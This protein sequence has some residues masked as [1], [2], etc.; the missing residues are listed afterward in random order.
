MNWQKR[1]TVILLTFFAQVIGY[2][3][4]VNI[5]IAAI[6]MQEDLGWTDAT[7]GIVLSS[8]FVGYLFCMIIGG[9][10]SNRYG[11]KIVL[12]VAVVLWSGFTMLTP[13]AAKLGDRDGP[14]QSLVS[15]G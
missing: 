15:L 6:A 4:R 2:T 3:D 7:K 14:W 1:Y 8:F 10:L 13:L 12:G 5:S 11:G 9:W